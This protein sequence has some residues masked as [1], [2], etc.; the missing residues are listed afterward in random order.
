VTKIK[1]LLISAAHPSDDQR[2]V[3]KIHNSL[4]LHYDVHLA[5][6]GLVTIPYDAIKIP[7]F[8][9]IFWRIIACQPQFLLLFLMIRPQ[10][11]HIFMAE[12]MPLGFIFKCLGAE[13]IYEVQEN[14]YKKI[15]TKT[16]NTG[17]LLE[18]VFRFFDRQARQYFHFVFTEKNYLHQYST[19]SKP[20]AV[21]QNFAATH[22]L[23][24]PMPQPR[25]PDFLYVGVISYERGLDVMLKALKI[26]HL[27]HP[28]ARLH[29]VGNTLF[30]IPKLTQDADYKAVES[31]V[32]L[33]GFKPQIEAFAL[34][35]GCVGGLAVLKAVGDYADSYPT[36]LF[37]YMALGL[38][39][40][41]SDFELYRAVVLPQNAGFC[42]NPTDEA[43]LADRMSYLINN[44]Q[45]AI[46]MGT[47]GR[48]SV[49]DHYNWPQEAQKLLAFY[50]GVVREL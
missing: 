38:P 30:S 35:K 41:T 33:H 27:T 10:I 9:S 23:Q 37:D 45:E 1:V 29:L 20:A 15:P 42:V 2:I 48:K 44:P 12:L 13:V 40:I 4:R 50:E 17:W 18:R 34:A 25:S 31:H 22:W 14:L 26:L 19:L 3:G 21:I 39:V 7:R 5:L 43:Q 46:K 6:P 24:L 47:N 49:V 36:K 28:N 16:W 11:V 32:I 8:K